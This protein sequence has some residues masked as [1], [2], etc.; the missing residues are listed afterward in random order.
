M[1][2][3]KQAL[4]FFLSNSSGNKITQIDV[5]SQKEYSIDFS[6]LLQTV[7][8]GANFLYKD[9]GFNRGD[10][11][12]Y[13][14]ENCPEV[15][16]LNL[17]CFLAGLRA[18]PLDGKRDLANTATR[19]LQETKTKA[20]FYK[21]GFNDNLVKE[22]KQNFT[23]KSFSVKDFFD[24]AKLFAKSPSVS[25]LSSDA[26]KSVFA[27]F[28]ENS[29][30]LVLY[31]SGTTGFPKG[32]LLSFSNLFYGAK[33]VKDWFKIQKD[34]VFYLILPLHHINSVVFSLATLLAGGSLVISSRYSKSRFF[35][36][37]AKY[38]VT[39]SS[40]VAT[41]NLDLLEE[42]KSFQKAKS[43]LKFRRIQIGSAP[44]S[45]KHA[46]EF[47][48]KYGIKLIQGYGS[49]ETSL[50][51]T[52]IPT[53]AG[54]KLYQ[55]L[56]KTNSIGKALSQ[57]EVFIIDKNGSV[58]EKPGTEGEICV[59]GKNIMQ[60][61]LGRSDETRNALKNGVFHTQDLGYFEKING[62]KY[63]FLKGRIKELI[64]K[65]GINISPIFIEER[66]RENFPFVK[67]V[68][69][70]GFPHFRFGEEIGAIFI[71]K[72]QNCQKEFEKAQED[73]RNNRVKNLSS[74]E[75][76]KVAILA[77]SDQIAK[78]ATGK[79]QH[80]KVREGFKDKLAY[81]AKLLGKNHNYI[82]RLIDADEE[83][84]LRKAIEIHNQVFPKSLGLDFATITHRAINGFVIGGF[85]K[86]KLA[87][88]LTGFFVKENML[89][90][91]NL[92]SKITGDG[93]FTTA[94]PKGNIALLCSAASSSSIGKAKSKIKTSRK[95]VNLSQKQILDYI[96]KAND[97]VVKFHNQPKAG[98]ETGASVYR[99]IPKGNIKDEESLGA[100][101]MFSYPE[102][103]K[104]QKPIFTQDKIGFGLVEAAIKYAKENGREK[105]IALSRLGEAQDN[106][107]V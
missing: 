14:F 48:K 28:D 90:K 30:C 47:V 58:V 10:T 45:V 53:N 36:D 87:G 103:K 6:L 75:T 61:Y 42:E 5:N 16:A 43:K 85:E 22:I 66:L 33:Q 77:D 65:G 11:I 69:V 91:E 93:K 29:P 80:V 88:A 76:P 81:E 34:D 92:W 84:L 38:S 59:K 51:A 89:K 35:Q 24:L 56:L 41:I 68:V 79:V 102:L 18:C 40:I 17:T 101:V 46:T 67:D 70:V 57:N 107:K 94:S 105:V 86:E 20:F 7:M 23:V 78:T 73:L 49:T 100:V 37:C 25:T 26:K 82:Y 63:Y 62:E 27:N 60:G 106:L 21:D 71:P 72:N 83:N 44:V 104:L 95:K 12:S 32:A 2:F 39:A 9:L 19:K 4:E 52:G 74:Y 1:D 50:R 96:K 15:I 13:L 98:F 55:R 54:N 31:T 8:D 64:I 97:Y 99:I 3:P